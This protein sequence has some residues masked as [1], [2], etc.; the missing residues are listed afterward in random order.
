MMPTC[1]RLT[2]VDEFLE[3]GATSGAAAGYSQVGID[4]LDAGSIPPEGASP[5]GESI[6]EPKA[7]LMIEHLLWAGLAG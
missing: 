4:D 5:L 6:L 7:L 2:R 3:S 1:P